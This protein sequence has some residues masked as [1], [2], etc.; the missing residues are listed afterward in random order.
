MATCHGREMGEST[1]SSI[2][3]HSDISTLSHLACEDS[4]SHQDVGRWH[5]SQE[6]IFMRC[7]QFC[8]ANLG[9]SKKCLP[10]RFYIGFTITVC[11][12][13]YHLLASQNLPGHHFAVFFKPVSFGICFGFEVHVFFSQ[14]LITWM[15]SEDIPGPMSDLRTARKTERIG[16]VP[17]ASFPAIGVSGGGPLSHKMVGCQTIFWDIFGIMHLNHWSS[18]IF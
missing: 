7:L 18:T 14:V 3:G 10:C 8:A 5:R 15:L 4:T 9:T 12:I 11:N 6:N 16:G 2:V 13:F 17:P 1:T